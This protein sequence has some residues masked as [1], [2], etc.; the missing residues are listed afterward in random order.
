MYVRTEDLNPATGKLNTGVPVEPLILRAKAGDCI[1]V[2]LTNKLDPSASV[3]QQQMTMAPPFS[4]VNPANGQ[5]V[6]KSQ[7]SKVTGLHPQL[8][9]YDAASSQGM[10]IGW[11][12]QGRPDQLATFGNKVAYTWYAGTITRSAG[13]TLTYTPVEFGSLN[14][15]PSDLMYQQPNGLFGAMVIEPSSA[16]SWTCDGANGSQVSCEPIAAGNP[17]AVTR[18]AATINPPGNPNTFREFVTMFSDNLRI[19]GANASAVNYRTEPQGFRFSGFST[20]DFSCMTSNQLVNAD[21]QTPIFTAMGGDKVRF[22]MFHTFGTGTS[23]VFSLHGHNW[24]RNP[25]LN[26]STQLGDQKLS[27]WLGSRDNYGSSDHADIMIRSAGGERAVPGDYLYTAF[28]P[29]Q[30]AQGPWGIFRVGSNNNSS[31]T[32][33]VLTANPACPQTPAQPSSATPTP[34]QPDLDRFV[35][36]PL[37]SGPRP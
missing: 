14:L 8:L 11:N 9:S 25:Y 21:P 17:Q 28:V 20:T 16:Q 4:G 5:P 19:S 29:I 30:G 33:G 23:Q 26:N 22:R 3:F 32:D 10:N 27:Q 24:Q 35:R 34:K 6:F 18:A 37:N 31:G 1:T 7:M 2:N 13:G 12:R 15:F 36:R